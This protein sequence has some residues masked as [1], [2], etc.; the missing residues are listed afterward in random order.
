MSALWETV[1]AA[2]QQRQEQLAAGATP[3]EAALNMER[4]V[5]AAWPEG[6]EYHY[7]CDTCGDTGWRLWRCDGQRRCGCQARF[8]VHYPH[9]VADFCTCVKGEAMRPKQTQEAAIAT[10]GKVSRQPSRFGR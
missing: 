10:V 7:L 2:M 6:Q 5:R 9:E 1:K 3:E 8:T 4:S